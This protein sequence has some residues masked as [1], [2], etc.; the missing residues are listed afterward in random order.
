MPLIIDSQVI[1]DWLGNADPFEKIKAIKG[2]V[3]RSKEGRTTQCFKINGEGFY[4]KLHE[5]IG[6]QEVIK[7]L[8]Q[9]RLPITG[10]SNEWLAIKKLHQLGLDT[11]TA[12][13]YGKR[14][15][16]PAAEQSFIITEELT[17]TLS[18]AQYAEQWPENPPAFSHK[19][20]II[21]KVAEVASTM[22]NHG[23]NHRDLYIC[24]FLLDISSGEA[25]TDKE[26]IRLFIVDLHRAQI[27]QQVPRRWWVKDV[28]SIY[29]SAL[30]IGL[31]RGDVYRFLR[32][33]YQM[34]LKDIFSQHHDFLRAVE[35]RAVK[36][37]RRDFKR[38]PTLI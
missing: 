31:T 30:D 33:Y 22:H 15:Y 8:L 24:H 27:R 26:K 28:G 19:K 32:A 3:V 13:A 2:K 1:R 4:V 36:L 16:N 34:P 29:F 20:A 23:I 11:L 25:F 6:W 35:R 5:G 12:V 38:T 14:G 10:A 37:Y 9:L 21:E 17:D 18:L 7:N